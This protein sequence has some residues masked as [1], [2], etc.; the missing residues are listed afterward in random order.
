MPYR[1]GLV[2]PSSNTTM[3]T[4][5]PAHAA[6]RA[7]RSRPRR[8][9]FHSSRMRM[10]QVT[11]EELDRDG[12]ATATAARSSSPTR[13]VDVHRATPASWRS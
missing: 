11:K 7:R 6:P 3:E 9:T 5:I 13:G 2:V 4:E 12:R 10:Q 8:F 1:I